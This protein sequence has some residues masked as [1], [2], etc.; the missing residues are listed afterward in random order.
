MNDSSLKMD[1]REKISRV[2]LIGVVA[3]AL[4]LILPFLTAAWWSAS[5]G[6]GAADFGISPFNVTISGLGEEF[7]VPIIWY[8]VLGARLVV[9]AGGALMIL[10][11]IMPKRSWSENLIRFGSTKLLWM[12]GGLI[13]FIFLG[14]IIANHFLGLD[15]PYLSGSK[16]IS[17]SGGIGPIDMPE[18]VSVSLP[19]VLAFS[20]TFLL[21]IFTAGLAIA[22][23]IYHGRLYGEEEEGDEDTR[24]YEEGEDED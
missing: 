23:R 11:S 9:L 21:A 24:V 19:L 18:G 14:S 10:G 20:K 12:I 7:S 2:N 22:A 15:L 16:A 4:M 1:L 5:V 6:S 17:L 8:A 3:G 13:A